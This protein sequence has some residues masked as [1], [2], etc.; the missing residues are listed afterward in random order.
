VS[1][2]RGYSL[3]EVC[4]AIFV[5]TI[6]ILGAYSA[7]S[8][9]LNSVFH[10]R[11]ISVATN[12]A[13]LLVEAVRLKNLP[14]W[15]A[16]FPTSDESGLFDAPG[17]RRALNAPPFQLDLPADGQFSRRVHVERLS[18]DS[19]SYQYNIARI[20]VTVYWDEKGAEKQVQVKA[21]HRQP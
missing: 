20:S 5:L 12:N 17:A 13:R 1:D 6:G 4:I 19:N 18:G 21:F 11:N 15:A 10:A 2:R 3:I 14:P 7:F 8:F 16:T 9:S